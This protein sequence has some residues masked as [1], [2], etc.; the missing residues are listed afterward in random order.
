[1]EVDKLEEYTSSWQLR[2]K[3][4]MRVQI[5]CDGPKTWW[6]RALALV[7][8]RDHLAFLIISEDIC[9]L[10]FGCVLMLHGTMDILSLRPRLRS[11]T[12]FIFPASVVCRMHRSALY[13]KSSC[14]SS[15]TMNAPPSFWTY[16]RSAD[17][18]SCFLVYV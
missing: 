4:L 2:V 3:G 6:V 5:D 16:L 12:V 9:S 1:M 7:G 14:E 17:F 13:V 8:V 15:E 11:V 18:P 10:N